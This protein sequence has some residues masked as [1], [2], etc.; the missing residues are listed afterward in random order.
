MGAHQ[1]HVPPT[2][3]GDPHAD[4]VPRTTYDA[5]WT[6]YER[7]VSRLLEAAKVAA[8]VE[9]RLTDVDEELARLANSITGRAR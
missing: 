2:M 9:A 3:V 4:C 5:L 8:R 6:E 7:V 1:H